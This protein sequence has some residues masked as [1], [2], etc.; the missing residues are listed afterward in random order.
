MPPIVAMHDV[1]LKHIG[2]R[3][4]ALGLDIRIAPFDNAGNFRIDGAVVPARE[5]EIDYLWLSSHINPV[6]T[7]GEVFAQALA[8]K[9]VGV[10]QTF[11]AGLDNPFYAKLAAKGVRILNSSA[12]GVAIAEYVMGQTLAVL[13][14][15]EEQRLMQ[16]AK[17]WRVTRF[18][19]IS[20]TH[21]LIV[22]FGP[23]GSAVAARAKAFG[24]KV[25]VLRRSDR[26]A[27][28]TDRVGVLADGP[29]FA[30]DADVIVLACPLND[31]TRGFAGA[32][33]FDAM[34]PGAILVNIARGGVIDDDAMIAALD[35]G[36]LDRA[37]LDVFYKEPLPATSPLW[38]HPKIRI[39]PHTSFAG[40]GVQ[41]RWDALFFDNIQ[42]FVRGEPLL[43]EVDPRDI[44]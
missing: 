8:C 34:K 36:R 25:S 44:I 17:E 30:A 5:A 1:S 22:G 18:R 11:N 24:A 38:T 15:I 41:A 27:A 13:Q 43:Q 29:A 2:P 28:H 35:S 12:Q 6:N 20:R 31:T 42:R 19:E 10:L 37:I 4:E 14:P 3:L 16:A 23:I 39:T 9:S 21:W 33:F 32:A 26:P 7:G 40:D